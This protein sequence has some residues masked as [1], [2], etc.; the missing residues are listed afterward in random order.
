VVNTTFTTR[1]GRSKV[2]SSIRGT[3]TAIGEMSALLCE[4]RK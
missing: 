2:T 3:L 1:V 4:A